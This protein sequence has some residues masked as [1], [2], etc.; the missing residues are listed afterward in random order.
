MLNQ[1]PAKSTFVIR[2][3]F[4][5]ASGVAFDIVTDPIQ[6]PVI[7]PLITRVVRKDDRRF[8]FY[9]TASVL[10]FPY[11]FQYQVIL[12]YDA[13]NETVSMESEVQKGLWIKL[14]FAFEYSNKQCFI[15]ENIEITG[16]FIARKLLM[17]KI[18]KA[19]FQ[20]FEN[21]KRVVLQPGNN[22]YNYAN[23]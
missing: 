13:V 3:A 6:F 16:P 5:E 9:E 7:H 22:Q 21:L 15:V 20:M 10:F 4:P 11:R 18:K 23:C 1:A 2:T 17:A 14:D 19:H 8:V 12:G